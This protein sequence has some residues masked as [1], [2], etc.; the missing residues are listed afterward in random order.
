MPQR[1]VD[2]KQLEYFV[3]VADAG[4]FSRA[5]RLLGVAQPALSRQVRALEVEL[6]QNLL[7]RNG[8]G[9]VPTE[10]GKRLLDHGRGIVQQVARARAEVE[11]VKGEPV[12]HVSVALP[13]T[14]ARLAAAPLVIAFRQRFPRATVSIVE[15]LSS[16]ILEWIVVGRADIG[17]VYNPAPSP[18]IDVRPLLDEDLSLIVPRDARAGAQARSVRLRDLPDYPLII[19]SRPHA[20]RALVE[21]RLAAIGRRPTVALEVDAVSAIVEL[22]AEGLGHAILSPQALRGESAARRLRARA[23]V[24]ALRSSLAVVVSAHRPAT[25]LQSACV[26]LVGS[27]VGKPLRP[28]R[29]ATPR[30][31]PLARGV[32]RT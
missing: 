25:L 24:P 10:A 21:A 31:P 6:R 20:I 8:R 27:V 32:T 11:A 19:P 9:A 2:L 12:G 1:L 23:I 7:V 28:A 26:A 15:G 22:V 16:T 5:A 30:G 3:A 4:G 17:L 18:A 29:T 14:L 13:P